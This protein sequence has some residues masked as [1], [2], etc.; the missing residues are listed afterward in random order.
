VLYLLTSLATLCTGFIFFAED[1]A[2]LTGALRSDVRIPVSLAILYFAAPAVFLLASAL[3]FWTKKQ[4]NRGR[5]ITMVA[6]LVMLTPLIQREHGWKLFIETAGPLVSA[7]FVLDSMVRSPSAIAMMASATSG[8]GVRSRFHA[9]SKH[10]H[11]P[12]TYDLHVNNCK[13]LKLYFDSKWLDEITVGMVEN[14][15]LSRMQEK[16]WGDKNERPISGVTVNRALATL[17]LLFN[18]AERSGYELPNPVKGIEFY[19]EPKRLRVI[20]L[21]E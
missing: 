21:E 11:R 1:Y 6:V 19:K 9:W 20:S 7:V 14:F 18:Y 8:R 10:Q 17:R 5:W 2:P 3:S 12:K 4:S 13:S 16:R 15:K